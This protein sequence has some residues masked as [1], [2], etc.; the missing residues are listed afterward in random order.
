MQKALTA[1]S[2]A[3]AAFQH[4]RGQRQTPARFRSDFIILVVCFIGIVGILGKVYYEEEVLKRRNVQEEITTTSPSLSPISAN[5]N[6][7]SMYQTSGP[8]VEVQKLEQKLETLYGKSK[9]YSRERVSLMETLAD[10]YS[11]V[12]K[13]SNAVDIR[14][15][16][17]VMKSKENEV[18]LSDVVSTYSAISKDYQDQGIY[19]ESLHWLEKTRKY[20]RTCRSEPVQALDRFEQS[21]KRFPY[22]LSSAQSIPLLLQHL[23]LIKRVLKMPIPPPSEIKKELSRKSRKIIN[24]LMKLGQYESKQQLP[25]VYIQNLAP[26]HSPWLNVSSDFPF[27][28]PVVKLLEESTGLL[29]EEYK[30]LKE[31]KRLYLE[32][33]C[34]HNSDG[35]V[36]NHYSVNG[37][38]LPL[39]SNGCSLETPNA[40]ALLQRIQALQLSNLSVLRAGYS[41][42][43][44]KGYLNPHFGHTNAQLK[45]HLGLITPSDPFG[46]G[47]PCAHIRV[48]NE[49]RAWRAGEVL[50][51]D[52]SWEHE[53]EHV[54][55]K[56]A[57]ERVV[58]QFVFV[59]PDY[60]R[61]QREKDS[62]NMKIEIEPSG[63]G[64]MRD[65]RG[66]SQNI[67]LEKLKSLH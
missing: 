19:G 51:F 8:L 66:N 36:W 57:G 20:L 22:D 24:S 53:V 18:T 32:T 15:E 4:R 41:M 25:R 21:V 1:L 62:G 42:I 46:S 63:E 64:K 7:I 58:F 17:L 33:E 47:G 37:F 56:S 45:F 30:S 5:L 27:L 6:E 28:S 65:S 14:K 55:P 26:K 50:F 9:S 48:G 29:V 44:A 35:G 13:P 16:I 49:S 43:D 23:D 34:I 52:D 67:D 11:H 31:R 40:C 54:C 60:V 2:I 61:K 38:W 3:F 39:D 59:H 10:L 12:K